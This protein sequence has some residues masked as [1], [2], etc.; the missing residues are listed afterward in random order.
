[1]FTL[2][3]TIAHNGDALFQAV[4][5]LFDIMSVITAISMFISRKNEQIKQ[6]RRKLESETA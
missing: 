6:L 2:I 1:M 3:A 5:L 4:G